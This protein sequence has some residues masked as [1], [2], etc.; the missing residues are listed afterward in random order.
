M[1]GGT[2]NSMEKHNKTLQYEHI[3]E[4]INQFMYSYEEGLTIDI[5]E[6]LFRLH[7]ENNY[8]CCTE[9]YSSSQ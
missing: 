9:R 1:H 3:H 4:F 5:S 6:I 8:E 7:A 2:N